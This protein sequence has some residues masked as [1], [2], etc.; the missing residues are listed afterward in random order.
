MY[1]PNRRYK[2]SLSVALCA[3]LLFTACGDR[4]T[5]KVLKL[6]HGLSNDHPVHKGM[7]YMADALAEKSGGTMRIDIYPSQQ[8]GTER[9]L[10]ELVQIGSLAMVKTSGAVLESFSPSAAVLSLPYVFKGQSH[11]YKIFEGEIGKEILVGAEKF[12]LRGLTYYDAGSRSYY[13]VD[14]P[15]KHPDDL[16]G[17]KIRVQESKTAMDMVRSMG[18]SPT[19]ISWGELYTSLQQGVVDGAE[20]NPPSFHLSRHYE[21]AKYYSINEHTGVP[22]VLLIGTEVWNDLSPQQQAWVQEAADES[23][24]AQKGYWKESVDE[25]LAAVSAAGVEIIRP[26]KAPFMEKVNEMLE[27]YKEVQ[28]EIYELIQRIQAVPE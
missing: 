6:G 19:P 18:G 1:S 11:R 20:N 8:L 22:D 28:P 10:I 24:Q 14:K 3:M 12:R 27:S 23:F 9:Q 26:D 4:G 21:I 2:L 15:V 25:A 5:V 16:A 13:T 7:A 17:L